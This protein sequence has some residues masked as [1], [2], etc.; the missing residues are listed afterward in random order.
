MDRPTKEQVDAALAAAEP[1]EW[2][3][4]TEA[5]LARE[6]RG[7]REC[8]RAMAK[9]WATEPTLENGWRREADDC[10]IEMLDALRGEP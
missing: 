10:A 2:T 4:G 1:W 5:V 7:L 8:L 3:A 9:K 6:V